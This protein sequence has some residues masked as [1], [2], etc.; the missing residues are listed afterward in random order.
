MLEQRNCL[1]CHP[2]GTARGNT[3]LAGETSKQVAILKGQSQ[4]LI[5]PS[6]TSVGDKLVDEALVRAIAGRQKRVR[7]PWL[8]IRMPRFEHPSQDSQAP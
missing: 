1:T 6:L 4:A 7:L 2:R 3:A 8:K 5:P